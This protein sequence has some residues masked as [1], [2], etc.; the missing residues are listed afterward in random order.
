MKKLLIILLFLT[1]VSYA[2]DCNYLKS[3]MQNIDLNE[4]TAGNYV[5]NIQKVNDF[6]DNKCPSH[7]DR[8]YQLGFVNWMTAENSSNPP[9]YFIPAYNYF[10][11]S[12]SDNGMNAEQMALKLGEFY[13]NKSLYDNAIIWFKRAGE[14]LKQATGNTGFIPAYIGDIY[15]LK[16]DCSEK[17]LD[18][19]REAIQN[20]TDVQLIQEAQQKAYAAMEYCYNKK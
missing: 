1:N 15:I 4:Y 3:R 6:Y 14:K 11:Q 17:T 7:Y 20:M 2:A 5:K 12:T 13:K 10:A 9:K 8:N 16:G 19:Y 18:Y